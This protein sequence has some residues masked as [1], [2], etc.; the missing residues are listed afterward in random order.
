MSNSAEMRRRI[1]TKYDVEMEKAV[2]DWMT[3]EPITFLLLKNLLVQFKITV[4]KLFSTVSLRLRLHSG[5]VK[6]FLGVFRF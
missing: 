5:H 4:L 1:A 2:L 3:G 6:T